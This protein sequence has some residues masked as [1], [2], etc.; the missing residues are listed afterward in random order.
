MTS[1]MWTIFIFNIKINSMKL[2]M[3]YRMMLMTVL[4]LISGILMAQEM[5]ILTWEAYKTKFS[6]PGNLR[7]I[8]SSGD[9]WSGTND[10][11]NIS[12]KAFRDEKLTKQEK[13]DLLY[14]WAINNGMKNIGNVIKLDSSQFNGFCGIMYEGANAGFPVITAHLSYPNDESVNFYIWISY[15]EDSKDIALKTL[16]SFIPN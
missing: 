12:I 10:T 8:K 14:N 4:L 7:V 6:I 1:F 5:K 9:Y 3:I 11:I 16:M 15:R 2:T 13:S